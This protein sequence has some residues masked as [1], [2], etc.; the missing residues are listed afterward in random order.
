MTALASGVVSSAPAP[1]AAP[2]P[3]APAAAPAPQSKADAMPG[4]PKRVEG[5]AFDA[6]AVRKKALALATGKETDDEGDE[7]AKT[8]ATESKPKPA[9]AKPKEEGEE[10][11]PPP[12][13]DLTQKKLSEGFAK[14]E[15]QRRRDQ[16]EFQEKQAAFAAKEAEVTRLKAEYEAKSK[17]HQDY[18][19]DPLKLLGEH[20]WDVNRVVE[21][22]MSDGQVPPE[23]LAK[24]ASAETQK[25][26]DDQ[27]KEL[28][29]IKSERETQEV[30][31]KSS[32]W[33]R[34]TYAG[35]ENKL[36]KAEAPLDH[37][38]QHVAF[39][40]EAKGRTAIREDVLWVQG[41][42]FLKT[43]QTLDPET[44]LVHLEQAYFE[45]FPNLLKRNP[46]QQG[47]GTP[48]TTGAEKPR[49]ITSSDTSDV[50]VPTDEELD[51]MTPDE[52]RARALKIARGSR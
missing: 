12:P 21:F 17:A 36:G 48:A 6:D 8:P 25:R 29:R 4:E 33:E 14:L 16:K 11:L 42:H 18:T 9:E 32:E 26:L 43:G 28:D 2:P 23:V 38:L 30:L 24:K 39:I 19:N 5:Q 1:A 41:Q 7:G 40:D 20:G 46:A 13:A 3:A 27:Q 34:R 35:I 52:R 15:R 45:M 51:R 44:A 50:S 31:A 49:Q 10:D 22:I 47:A 37:G